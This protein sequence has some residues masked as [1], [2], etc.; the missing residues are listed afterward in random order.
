MDY[1]TN[2]LGLLVSVRDLV[3]PIFYIQ[4]QISPLLKDSYQKHIFSYK[5]TEDK[6]E[7]FMKRMK[8]TSMCFNGDISA[9]D[10]EYKSLGLEDI[11][12][13]GLG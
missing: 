12:K 9:C 11:L 4:G 2:F 13:E 8:K 6:I 3:T 1:E 7:D 10:K 5:P